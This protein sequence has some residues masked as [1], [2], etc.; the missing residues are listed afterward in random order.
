MNKTAAPIFSSFT[1]TK[2]KISSLPANVQSNNAMA[3]IDVDNDGKRELIAGGDDGTLC[4]LQNDEF[5]VLGTEMG[6]VCRILLS[7]C[8]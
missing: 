8:V 1:C 4:M 3:W 6:V 7:V 2:K 5:T